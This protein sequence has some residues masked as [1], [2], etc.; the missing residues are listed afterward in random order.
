MLLRCLWK[1]NDLLSIFF[2]LK[3]NYKNVSCKICTYWTPHR[4][5]NRHLG[6]ILKNI[7]RFKAWKFLE[8]K[9]DSFRKPKAW[10]QLRNCL[11]LT[12]LPGWQL[13]IILNF[14]LF[15]FLFVIICVRKF[16]ENWNFIKL[17]SLRI[18]MVKMMYWAHALHTMQL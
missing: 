13:A 8:T 18:C 9:F 4:I 10:V 2:R 16:I 14:N 11:I 1:D 7:V 12:T 15:F 3:K 5:Q 6:W 17:I